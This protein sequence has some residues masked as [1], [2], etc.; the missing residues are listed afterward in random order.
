M[1]AFQAYR[2]PLVAMLDFKY[3]GR[4]LTASDN[5]CTAVAQNFRKAQKQWVRVLRI[6]G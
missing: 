4:V 1:E 2:R 5:D 3:L 6:L